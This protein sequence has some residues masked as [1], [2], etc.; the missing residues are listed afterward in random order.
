MSDKKLDMLGLPTPSVERFDMSGLDSSLELK[1]EIKS[2]WIIRG[3]KG[4]F[5]VITALGVIALAVL[6]FIICFTADS[7]ST[8][9]YDSHWRWK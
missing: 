9:E 7:K 6:Y 3:F 4:L 8:N 1:D 5:K 2:G